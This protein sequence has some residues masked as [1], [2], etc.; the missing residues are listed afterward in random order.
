MGAG[1]GGVR[2]W[3]RDG[4]SGEEDGAGCSAE[5]APGLGWGELE[6]AQ[7]M[8]VV[9]RERKRPA[10]VCTWRDVTRSGRYEATVA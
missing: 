3:R 1:L 2:G 6:G 10:V 8:S 7:Q 9:E 5:V 4:N